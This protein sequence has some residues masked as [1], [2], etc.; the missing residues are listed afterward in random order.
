MARPPRLQLADGIYHVTSRGVQKL[1]V[2]RDDEDRQSFL[3]ILGVVVAKYAWTCL[4]YCEM[5]NHFHLLVQTPEPNIA[6]GMRLLNGLYARTFNEKHG[7]CGHLFESRYGSE[8]IE[9]EEQL[10]AAVLYIAYNP[11]V[12]GLCDDPADWLWSSTAASIGLRPAPEFLHTEVLLDLLGM[13]RPSQL[14]ELIYSDYRPT[15]AA[16]V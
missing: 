6:A 5:T 7:L 15:R 3:D 12:A 16:A 1:P 10:V 8:L 13:R 11:V 2:F 9:T 14:A 4:E